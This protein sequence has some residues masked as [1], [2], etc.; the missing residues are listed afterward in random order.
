M[1]TEEATEDQ[2]DEQ[3]VTA[4]EEEA[5]D[6]K[7]ALKKVIAVVQADAGTLRKSL[8]ITVPA[9]HL[10]AE[11]D[12]DYAEILSDAVIP[13]FRR[14][15]APRKLVE[16]RFGKE[17]GE[18]V[19][20]RILSNAY[21][22]AI[23][24]EDL[25]VLGDPLLWV[26]VKDKKTP[27]DDGKE[28]LLDFQQ[29]LKH[30]KLP[31]EG[32]FVFRCEVEVKPQFEPPSLERVR[33]E[34]PDLTITDEDVQVQIDRL[35]SRE[36]AWKPVPAGESVRRDDLL[37]CDMKLSVAGEQIKTV[38]NMPLAARPQMIEGAVIGDFYE[39]LKG[40]KIGETR[41]IEATLPDDHELEAARGKQATFEFLLHEI[42][43]M[44]LPP[45]DQVFLAAQGFDSEKEYREW[46][47][48]TMQARLGQEIQ[49]GMRTQ[50]RRY[51]LEN[52]R[53]DLPEGL[54]SRQTQRAVARRV[55]YLRRQGV[56][57]EEIAKHADDLRTSAR[58]QVVAE[59]KLHFILE[60]IAENFDIDVTEEEVNTHIAAIARQ[61]NRRFDRV[62]D[63]LI[64]ENRIYDLYCDIRDE[65]C[66]DRI[67]S[68][69]EIVEPKD[70]EKSPEKPARK[71][72]ARK[73][74]KTDATTSQ[75]PEA[76]PAETDAVP[77]E[78]PESKPK[79]KAAK[80]SGKKTE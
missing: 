75:Q 80:K 58:E 9:D 77:S 46:V 65:K 31:D 38:E 56:P 6:P 41:S 15:R 55:V 78:Q 24:K 67:L 21:L 33:I 29:A 19:Q 45:L 79:K 10:K 68:T 17:V 7:E 14:G 36:G 47:R 11:L 64:R 28:T 20:T 13:G 73:T 74:A 34:R 70:A 27:H 3:D 53:L 12:K 71:K 72:A 25:K 8:Q 69:A 4:T 51:L 42:K 49:S 43:R 35:R 39:R 1:A 57:E 2:L 5:E 18:Q 52:T 22:A 63:E 32:D 40:M 37:V 30:L 50:V 66:I 54:S 16:K 59:L 61:M 60:E 62:R 26:R 44:E 23:E 76:K 48:E